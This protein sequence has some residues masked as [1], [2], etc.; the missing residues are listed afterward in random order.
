MV[1]GTRRED[2]Y[3][4]GTVHSTKVRGGIPY[5]CMMLSAAPVTRRSGKGSDTAMHD[6]AI[7]S[8]VC[9][10][11]DLDLKDR[12]WRAQR[13]PRTWNKLITWIFTYQT[14]KIRG[15]KGMHYAEDY[16]ELGMMIEKYGLDH[17]P[18]D[19]EIRYVGLLEKKR[20]SVA[21]L[22]DEVVAAAADMRKE[23]GNASLIS[24]DTTQ[25]S[26]RR[27]RIIHLH[28]PQPL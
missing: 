15:E 14:D 25:R 24:N 26:H 1:A 27:S 2:L 3:A 5:H 7:W 11:Y 21:Q 20:K 13:P 28:S 12:G 18:V 22:H 4:E 17:A 8:K 6:E 10:I 16:Y 9:Y 19:P 23:V